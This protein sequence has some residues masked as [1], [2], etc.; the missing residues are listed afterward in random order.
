MKILMCN[1]HFHPSSF[2]GA[3]IVAENLALDLINNHGCKVSVLTT[4]VDESQPLYDLIRYSMCDRVEVFSVNIQPDHA[5]GYVAQ[6]ENKE[7]EFIL[8][9]VCSSIAFDIL[10]FHSVQRMG[11]GMMRAARRLGL[12]YVITVHDAWWFCERQFMVDK[13]GS[14]CRQRKIDLSRCAH[15]VADIDRFIKRRHVLDEVFSGAAAI[16]CP[17]RHQLE[18]YREN[19][20]ENLN[21][22]VSENGVDL[23]DGWEVE[24]LRAQRLTYDDVCVFGFV[25]GPGALKGGDLIKNAFATLGRSDYKLVLVNA[26]TNRK[27]DWSEAL[28]WKISGCLE[29]VP[30]YQLNEAD[31]FYASID[32]LLH[33]SQCHE[34]FGL[35]VRE[36]SA[37]GV[38]VITTDSGGAAE[39]IVDGVN[40]AVI[41]IGNQVEE[42]KRLLTE[43]IDKH[44]RRL[45]N[46]SY[47]NARDHAAQ[48]FEI[49]RS[50][51]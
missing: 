45:K 21:F 11:V 1:V 42:L 38:W 30:G 6:Y 18:L 22:T 49:Y 20:S 31:K 2:G 39:A 47:K 44:P 41:P 13:H 36:A 23:G 27:E 16:L 17:S 32:V 25:G 14:F 29:I 48:T 10:H 4:H 46:S 33:P 28:S 40:G 7:I 43:C 24:R 37:R 50:V 8:E 51:L 15:C 3:T 35:T 5:V 34:S 9:M 26:A 19:Y 12:P